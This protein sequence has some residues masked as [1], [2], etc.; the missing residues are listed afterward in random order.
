LRNEKYTKRNISSELTDSFGRVLVTDSQL[1]QDNDIAH[2]LKLV[3][4][5]EG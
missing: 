4:A 1:G 2:A 5:R 3:G